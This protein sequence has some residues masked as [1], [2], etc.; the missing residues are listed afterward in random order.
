MKNSKLINTLSE[1]VP[2]VVFFVSY[3][4]Y[5]IIAATAGV[6]IATLICTAISYILNRYVSV[7]NIIATIIIAIFGSITIFTNNPV[8]IKLKPTI[9]SG[10]FAAILWFGVLRGRGYLKKVLVRGG[11]N[12]SDEA[13]VTLS[14]RYAIF[15]TLLACINE[16]VW[17]SFSEEIW[18]TF[19]VFGIITL[20]TFFVLSQIPFITR[21]QRA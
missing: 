15:L 7:I 9:V 18:V 17:R 10:I 1:I 16:I 2:L 8:F 5:G 21:N 4:L 14:K 3:K 11:M 19:K 6:V 13:W 20:S 12:M